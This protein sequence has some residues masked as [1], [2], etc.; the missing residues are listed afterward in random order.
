MDL[1][2]V[3]TVV[4][5]DADH[6]GSACPVLRI[7]GPAQAAGLAVRRGNTWEHDQPMEFTTAPM[8]EA[9]VVIIQR[10][11][12]R[13]V[14]AYERIMTAARMQGKLV[15]YEIDDLL[16]ELPPEHPGYY[17]YTEAQLAIVRAMVEAD[18]VTVSTAPLAEYARQFNPQVRVLP[19]CVNEQ[20][21]PST[22]RQRAAGPAVIG[23]VGGHTH[24]AD[25]EMIAEPLEAILTRYGDRIRL[26]F[27]SGTA[28]PERLAGRRNVEWVPVQLLEYHQFAR[29][30]QQQACDVFIA[31]LE[32]NLF[33]RCK[34]AIKYLEYSAL[35]VPGVY[36]QIAPYVALIQPGET[37][38][39][40]DSSEAWEANLARLIDEPELRDRIGRQAQQFAFDHWRL[41]LHAPLW[42]DAYAYAQAESGSA[43]PADG[44][45]AGNV[46]RLAQRRQADL[47]QQVLDKEKQLQE[48]RT[49]TDSVAWR[50]MVIFNRLILK[51][52]PHN[53]GRA[54]LLQALLA[55]LRRVLKRRDAAGNPR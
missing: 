26:K 7:V 51:L 46:V 33:N 15:V 9:E 19:N 5:Y 17:Y 30:I 8:T 32:D 14:S 34:S 52:A 55:P 37:G 12:P 35:G 47:E 36:S 44:G 16:I 49:I 20:I 29:Y 50:L 4:L 41:T 31:P 48:I 3:R 11:F 13:Y 45:P 23:Y 53:T 39:L 6:W 28:P 42:R 2:P 24:L 1:K 54:H 22:P 25:L 38:L 27:W 40:A 21:W 43:A 10:D 18:L